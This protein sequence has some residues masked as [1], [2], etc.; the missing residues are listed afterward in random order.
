MK[1]NIP[2]QYNRLMPYLI[3]ND[4]PAFMRF[5]ETVFDATEQT[6]VPD[7][8]GGIMHGE[9]RIGDDTVIMFAEATER[10]TAMNAGMFI[11]VADADETYGKALRAG[12]ETVPGQE[13]ADKPYGRTCGVTDPFGN[14]WWITSVR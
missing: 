3:V 1:T 4:A 14:A 10:F 2:A 7:G 5:M 6:T 13:P 9:L 12:A 11:H 8:K